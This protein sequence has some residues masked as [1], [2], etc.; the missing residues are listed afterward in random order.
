[1]KCVLPYNLLQIDAIC[2][3]QQV[4]RKVV[5][6]PTRQIGQNV[7]TA[8]ALSGAKWLNLHL[9]TPSDW[10][11]RIAGPRLQ[12]EGWRPLT[13]DAAS[14][15][16]EE[17]LRQ[18]A[19]PLPVETLADAVGRLVPQLRVAHISPAALLAEADEEGRA[20]LLAEISASLDRYCRDN[21]LYDDAILY[22]KALSLANDAPSLFEQS[23]YA[24]FDEV[25]LPGLALQFV[26][27]LAAL[28]GGLHRIGRPAGSLQAPK[29]SIARR[30]A[31]VPPVETPDVPAPVGPG[32]LLW[33]PDGPSSG[34]LETASVM[35]RSAEIRHVLRRIKAEGIPLDKVELAYT[36]AR[37]YLTS[38]YAVLSR[39]DVPVTFTGGL[40]VD[41]TRPG[42][43]LRHFYN[44][45]A[46]GLDPEALV[47]MLASGTVNLGRQIAAPDAVTLLRSA[48]V[49]RG[50]AAYD[51]MLGRLRDAAHNELGKYGSGRD[52]DLQ[53]QI[54]SIEA[55]RQAM[56]RLLTLVPAESSASVASFVESSIQFLDRYAI[57]SR[58]VRPGDPQ[59]K[60]LD[61]EAAEA[62]VARFR[63]LG[64]S[65]QGEW[66]RASLLSRFTA[67]LDAHNVAASGPRAGHL[68]VAP[69]HAAGYTGRPYVF[70]VGMDSASFP[71]AGIQDA[72]L[73]DLQRGSLSGEL[74]TLG[75]GP[76]E[77]NWHLVRLLS[78]TTGTAVL[79]SNSRDLSADR[80]LYPSALFLRAQLR[81]ERN[82]TVA[83][84][85]PPVSVGAAGWTASLLD[86]TEEALLRRGDPAIRDALLD[87]YPSLRHGLLAE[88]A[89]ASTDLT[90]YD[91]VLGRTHASFHIS[92]RAV[93]ASG[94]ELL[95]ACTYRYFLDRVLRLQKPAETEEDEERQW[96]D[97]ME[98]GS[99]VH[100]LLERFMRGLSERG[101]RV[102]AA[103]HRDELY[104]ILA[105]VLAEHRSVAGSS[106]SS[107]ERAVERRLQSLID[108]FLRAE[109]KAAADRTPTYFELLFG[110]DSAEPP[111]RRHPVNVRLGE[112][113]TLKLRGRIDRVD[114]LPDGSLA[115]VDYKTGQYRYFGQKDW[116]SDGKL[117]WALYAHALREMTG[118]PVSL[119]GYYF[120]NEVDYGLRVDRP[121]A[122][123]GSIIGVLEG[124]LKEA[125]AGLFPPKP[126]EDVCKYCDFLAIC[127]DPKQRRAQMNAKLAGPP[128]ATG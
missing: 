83:S 40:P 47:V 69:L 4:R 89:R 21:L 108:L 94:L 42:Q 119:S 111:G 31:H 70:V 100:A 34:S 86:R 45:I 99:T 13:D 120:L 109:A 54:S 46:T 123:V 30:F 23:L 53:K 103:R 5:F 114:R 118:E 33:E 25:S 35:G 87:L 91:G 6:V 84:L 110:M 57:R 15:V 26:E 20:S 105:E 79:L 44:W 32:G 43:A 16:I 62:L 10:A 50:R 24:A 22:E 17:A 78:M 82:E 102:D 59:G 27:R 68:S 18:Y 116:L 3:S 73:P 52:A 77:A 2:R 106:G 14:F 90:G 95:V 38:I 37:P 76:S 113:L 74:G 55:L 101:D 60:D 67:I 51:Q 49:G 96:M 39:Y 63:L 97:P 80:P 12:A 93:S 104:G 124:P 29:L 72:L 19:G 48:R 64:E 75:E 58:E 36:S 128:A 81:A 107:A 98:F 8:L 85:L 126:S 125:A 11:L 112:S 66:P 117:Q 1:M 71:G 88:S 127:G 7:G 9:T 61:K 41:V 121:P 65:V 115:I 28:G 92:D 56:Q 122:D